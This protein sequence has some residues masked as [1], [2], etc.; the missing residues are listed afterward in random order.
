M[1]E[2]QRHYNERMQRQNKERQTEEE[3]YRYRYTKSTDR[4]RDVGK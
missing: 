1:T 2:K 3:I 4:N